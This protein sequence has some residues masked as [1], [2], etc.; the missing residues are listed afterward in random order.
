[1]KRATIR[2]RQLGFVFQ[3]FHLLARTSAVEN[4]ALPMFYSTVPLHQ[5]YQRAHAAL[6]AVGLAGRAEH[7]PS[8]LS[9]GQQQRVAIARALVNRPSVLLADEPTGNLDTQA[10]GEI[11]KVFQQLNREAGITLLLVTHEPDIAAYADRVITFRDGQLIADRR[12]PPAL[13]AS[14]GTGAAP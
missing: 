13:S 11:L 4:V 1:D 9:G 6:A 14:V 5:Q 3:H 10:S 2:N 12:Q 7:T 8:Q